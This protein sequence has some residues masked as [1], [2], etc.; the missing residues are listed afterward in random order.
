VCL[1]RLDSASGSPILTLMPKDTTPSLL[2]LERER[3]KVRVNSDF[4]RALVE[5][6]ERDADVLRFTDT[7][8]VLSALTR[9]ICGL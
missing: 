2:S 9:A 7:L 6:F 8:P 4:V 3:R 5:R 1:S